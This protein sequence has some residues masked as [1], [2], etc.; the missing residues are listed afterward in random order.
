MIVRPHS[1]RLRMLFVWHGSVLRAILPELA[2][3]LLMSVIAWKTNGRI[4]G[5]KAA[6]SFTLVG[7]TLA[8]FLAFR[9]NVSY[10]RY[11]EA[12]Q[13]WGDLAIASRALLS[14]VLSYLPGEEQRGHRESILRHL[15]ALAHALKRQLRSEDESAALPMLTT[16]ENVALQCKQ[17]KPLAL[18]HSTRGIVADLRAGG[19]ACAQTSWMLDE[20]VVRLGNVV[21]GCERIAATPIPFPYAVLM[22]RTVFVY[23]VLLPFGLADVLHE[24]TPIV[25]VFVAYTLLGLEEISNEIADPF[26][27][28]P[29]DLAL[30][31]IVRNIERNLLELSGHPVPPPFEVDAHHVLR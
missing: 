17:F 3:M 9:N 12:R 27:T 6:T 5:E 14:Q 15:V 19:A 24:L 8:V 29:N 31:A 18:V 22:R 30:E 11:W 10:A 4:L 2:F 16:A 26:G 20:M 13:L 21:G 28:S 25:S 1:N 23:C 7:I